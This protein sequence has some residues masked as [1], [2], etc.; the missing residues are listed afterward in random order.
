MNGKN[1]EKE[2]QPDYIEKALSSNYQVEIDVWYMPDVSKFF[3]G[4]D[5][6]QYPIKKNFLNRADLWCH[7]KN[8]FALEKLT[9]LSLSSAFFWHQK[10]DFTLTS[11]NFIWTYPG[12]KLGQRSIAVLPETVDYKLSSLKKSAGICSD[13]IQVFERKIKI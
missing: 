5:E 3:L 4:H 9:E 13:C 11:N 7:A 10:D 12:Q 8:I 2:N 1:P 6:P